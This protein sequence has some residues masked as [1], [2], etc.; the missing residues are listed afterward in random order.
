MIIVG[1]TVI[2]TV[3]PIGAS[4]NRDMHVKKKH[5]WMLF[6]KGCTLFLEKSD[7]FEILDAVLAN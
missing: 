6:S 5:P 1:L 7:R 4:V 2:R 3:R